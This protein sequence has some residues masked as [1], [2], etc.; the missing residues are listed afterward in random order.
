MTTVAVLGAGS[1]GTTLAN[2]LAHKGHEVRLWAYE[3]EVVESINQRH[4]NSVF[5]TGCPLAESLHASNDAVDVVAGA[6]VIL[7]V[8]PSHAVRSV[9]GQLDRHVEP[10]AL[11]VSA[12]KG[13]ETDTLDLMHEVLAE[14]LPGRP[15]AV[16]SGPSFAREVYDGQPTAVVAAS[17]HLLHAETAQDVFATPR[18]RIY[19]NT[20][21]VGAELGG[22]LKNV[23]A[24]AAGVLEGLGMGHNPRAA[25]ITRGLAEITRLGEA[26]GADPHTFAG[27][28]GMGDLVLTAFGP[29]SRNH[30]L[31]VA[32]GQGESLEE[33]VARRRTV[34]EGVNT[35]RA[36]VRL[37]QRVGV[38]LPITAKVAEILFEGKPPRETVAEL[39][40]R[41]LKAERWA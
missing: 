8:I 7:S 29:Q 10:T 16:L 2:L 4:E 28:A 24:I 40:G 39:M 34:A 18:F 17:E 13:I 9:V 1:W 6:P 33:Y 5:L 23:I 15:L 30:S 37:A 31:G 26:L 12:T 27:L 22:S 25:L 35:A 32:L 19:T 38:E 3:T 20:D 14:C 11:V 21:V 41:D 36:A